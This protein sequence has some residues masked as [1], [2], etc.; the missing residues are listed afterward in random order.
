MMRLDKHYHSKVR[1]RLW[2]QEQ[3]EGTERHYR[4]NYG[5]KTHTNILIEDSLSNE[6]RTYV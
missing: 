1:P 6:Q 4:L 5:L 3:I 2:Y